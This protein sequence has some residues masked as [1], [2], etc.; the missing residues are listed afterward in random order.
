M[1]HSPPPEQQRLSPQERDWRRRG[2]WVEK[3]RTHFLAVVEGED[4]ARLLP[5]VRIVAPP[6]IDFR[7]HDLAAAS[8][9]RAPY[10]DTDHD[11]V[12]RVRVSQRVRDYGRTWQGS[13]TMRVDG[14]KTRPR[15]TITRHRSKNSCVT[16]RLP[17]RSLYRDLA[18]VA[19]D[20]RQSRF[21]VTWAGMQLAPSNEHFEEMVDKRVRANLEQ[22]DPHYVEVERLLG[23][24]REQARVITELERSV[25]APIGLDSLLDRFSEE[26]IV[27]EINARRYERIKDLPLET[28]Q[29]P[30]HP[31]DIDN[32][33]SLAE[34]RRLRSRDDVMGEVAEFMEETRRHASP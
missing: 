14:Y 18:E 6:V 33:I 24:T 9:I 25:Q 30:L 7:L 26:E 17:C 22:M 13:A 12:W 11:Q 5:N 31:E 32:I 15:I 34:A 3:A 28:R 4:I 23:V 1:D 10:S 29:D 8:P 20:L 16:L 27:A 2:A 19:E 21:E